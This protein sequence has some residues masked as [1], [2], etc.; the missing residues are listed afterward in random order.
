[1][2]KTLNAKLYIITDNFYSK[3]LSNYSCA[4]L[5]NINIKSLN[6]EVLVFSNQATA[7]RYLS[8]KDRHI[9]YH[10]ESIKN[11][12]L[13]FLCKCFNLLPNYV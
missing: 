3:K 9:G 13:K 2:S 7:N 6:N 1:M 12:D 4:T 5:S 10:I 8:L 11:E